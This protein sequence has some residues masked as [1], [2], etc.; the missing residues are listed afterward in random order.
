MMIDKEELL[1]LLLEI[2][3]DDVLKC[4]KERSEDYCKGHREGMLKIIEAVNKYNGL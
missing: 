3:Y 4:D 1:K 2:F